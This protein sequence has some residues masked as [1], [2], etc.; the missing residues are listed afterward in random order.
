MGRLGVISLEQVYQFDPTPPEL[1]AAQAGHILGAQGNVWSE[2]MPDGRA[3]E[4]MVLPRLCALAE[5]VWSS[6]A[7]RSW[8]D[9]AGRLRGHGARLEALDVPFYRDKSVWG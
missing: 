3:V 1:D 6:G 9:F 8:G 4:Q 5:V 2:G 7:G